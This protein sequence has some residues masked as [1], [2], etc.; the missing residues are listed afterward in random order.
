MNISENIM[1]GVGY[2]GV[3]SILKHNDF[4]ISKSLGHVSKKK[5]SQMQPTLSLYLCNY[6]Y[7]LNLKLYIVEDQ[8]LCLENV[9]ML[10]NMKSKIWKM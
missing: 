3:A 6:L 7:D 2:S 8:Q 1:T 5:L 10:C 9:L 4:F